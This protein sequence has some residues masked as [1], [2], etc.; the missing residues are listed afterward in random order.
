MKIPH[1]LIALIALQGFSSLS[2]AGT[3]AKQAVE[4][5]KR[6]EGGSIETRLIRMTGRFGQDQPQEWEIL[7][8]RGNRFAMYIVDRESVLS[9]SKIRTN[10]PKNLSMKAVQIDSPKAFLIADKSAKKASVSFDSL[11]Y[12]LKPR[13]DNG[14]PVWIVSLAD[15]VGITVG[16][17]HISADSGKVLLSNWDRGQLNRQATRVASAPTTSST[18]GSR[19]IIS[20]GRTESVKTSST[21]DGVR[22]GLANVGSSIRGVFRKNEVST[23]ADKRITPP[24]TNSRPQ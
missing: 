17:V 11:S 16:Q 22:G 7:A 24:T 15:S 10:A 13:S 18:G 8:R 9:V 12:D 4:T 5:L 19:G 3:S 23:A 14:N 20:D 1:Y 2:L 6:V 21:M